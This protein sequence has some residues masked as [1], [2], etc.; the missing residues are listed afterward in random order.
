MV[1]FIMIAFCIA[2]G[3]LLKRTN[4][5][6]ADAHKGI[7]T[8]ILYFALPAVSF[9]YI[10]KIVWSSQMLFPVLSTVLVWAGSWVFM[11]W[12]CQRKSYK[13]RSRSSLELAAGYSNTSFIG[14]PLIM[15]Y[16]G[17]SQ[18]PIAIICDQTTFILLST[19][20]IIN[21]LKA[22]LHE[23]EAIDA[24]FML[25]KLI[26]FPPLIGCVS[27]LLLS[28]CVDLRPAEPFFDKLVATVGPL[29]LFSIGLQL[30][31]DGWRQQAA[32][33]STAMLYKLV[34]APLLV[35]FVA[36]ALGV[37]GPVARISIFEAAMPTLVTSGIIAE[38][39]HLNTK[40]VNLVIGFSIV[41]GLLTTAV[42][43]LVI[44]WLIG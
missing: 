25:R 30:K 24:R 18:L 5:I 19:A 38:Q 4:L 42:W 14:F 40:L 11:Q 2:A 7:N 32:Q 41:V 15:A 34:L 28:Q 20:G 33:I 36:L 6:H 9:K 26:T 13:Q 29:A 8:W 12:Y 16:F 23:G 3:M 37:K 21:A 39:Y 35:L 1:N 43:D 31:F 44:Q 22:N 17:E 10:P 27:A